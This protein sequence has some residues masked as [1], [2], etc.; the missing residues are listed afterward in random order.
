MEER[1]E[2]LRM[3]RSMTATLL[4]MKTPWRALVL[5]K[6]RALASRFVSRVSIVSMM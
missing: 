1:S 6:A 3:A 5:I 2:E 4:A